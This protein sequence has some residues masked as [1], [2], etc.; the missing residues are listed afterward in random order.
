[1]ASDFKWDEVHLSEDPAD[2]LLRELGYEF[3][4]ADVLDGERESLAEPVLVK[5]S[6]A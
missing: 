4:A 2:A 3:I 6:D 5:R 1:M